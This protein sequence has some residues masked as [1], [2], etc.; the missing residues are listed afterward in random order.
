MLKFAM[1]G[2][3][4]FSYVPLRF[5]TWLGAAAGC[6]AFVVAGW[7]LFAKV[8]G[9]PTEPGWATIMIAVSL[10]SSA[11]LLMI[12]ILGEY[13]GRI[14]EEVKRRP[15]YVVESEVNAARDSET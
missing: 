3:V 10:A 5:A 12:G 7:A 13:V 4:S 11:Q 2:V 6:M 9:Q 14:Y 1:D 8:S 15:L